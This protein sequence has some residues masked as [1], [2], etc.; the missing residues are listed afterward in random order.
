MS[1]VSQESASV[2]AYL[3]VSQNLKVLIKLV[4]NVDWSNPP[5]FGVNMSGRMA[6]APMDS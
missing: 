5:C 1:T 2:D 4:G 6:S 3:R